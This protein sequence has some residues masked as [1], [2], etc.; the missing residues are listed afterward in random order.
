MD[1]QKPQRD[2]LFVWITLGA[3][4]FQG[5]ALWV[6]LRQGQQHGDLMTEVVIILLYALALGFTAW[7]V[8]KN[9]HDARRAKKLEAAKITVEDEC[10]TQAAKLTND[11]AAE[12]KRLS[13]EHSTALSHLQKEL[14]EEGQQKV[15]ELAHRLRSELPHIRA[16]GEAE[17]LA[18]DADHLITQLQEIYNTLKLENN[19]D[20]LKKCIYPLSYDCFPEPHEDD[21]WRWYHRRIS[22]FQRYYDRHKNAI[23]AANLLPL[24]TVVTQHAL[25]SKDF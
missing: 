5:L 13:N 8:Y 17:L 11:H 9:L 1:T 20:A 2:W 12:V 4:V 25:G 7:A 18:W 23:W 6:A 21:K 15:R 14:R 24:Q 19:E 16:S 10:K 22:V 3:A